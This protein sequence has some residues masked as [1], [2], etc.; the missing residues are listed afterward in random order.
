MNAI[1]PVQS[2]PAAMA[3]VDDVWR[4]AQA[5]ARSGLFGMKSPE[6]AMALMLIAQ[7]EGQHPAVAARDY[8]IVEGR[9]SLKADAM[10]ARF[11][12]AGGRVKWG[13]YTDEKVEATFSHPQGGEVTVDWT[14]KRA[15]Q[16]TS[17]GKKI[18]DKDNWRNYPRQML[19]ARVISEGIR[20]VY[21]GVAVGVYTPEEVQDFDTP[22][23][24]EV[25]E[26]PP[27]ATVRRAA[28]APVQ[29]L[30]PAERPVDRSGDL[31][32]TPAGDDADDWDSWRKVIA[33]KIRRAATEEQV[34]TVQRG[35]KD[36]LMRCNELL[37]DTL[38]ILAELVAKKLAQL[39]AMSAEDADFRDGA[40]EGV[41][42]GEHVLEAAD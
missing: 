35:H 8:H 17:R 14:I 6:E 36:A 23:V 5:V 13:A 27:K 19:R 40:P 12:Q 7:A 15:Q 29:E 30:P 21:P 1:V 22:R 31:V 4:M 41:A 37:P 42:D 2:N 39:G 33:A 38:T 24:T 34:L 11:I 26:A 32:P 25:R 16:I 10:L 3:P 28:E 9:P 18:T 20:T